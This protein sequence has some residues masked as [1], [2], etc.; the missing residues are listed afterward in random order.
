MAEQNQKNVLLIRGIPQEDFWEQNPHME[1][2]PAVVDLVKK[3]GYQIGGKLMWS[4]YLMMDPDSQ[5][6]SMD[7]N[8]R[9]RE[10][11]TNYFGN[12]DFDM[13]EPFLKETMVQYPHI[14]M[15]REKKRY[16]DAES[17]YDDMLYRINNSSDASV[18]AMDKI[19]FLKS[20]DS[21]A[22]NIDKMKKKWLDTTK[23]AGRSKGQQ[24][25]GL[26]SKKAMEKKANPV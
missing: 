19:S 23:N 24:Q 25:G 15:T 16:F 3:Y 14:A 26:F 18:R 5:F 11:M 1:Y 8:D 9:K 17:L 13:D 22:D 7:F 20:L 21:I 4:I 2:F 10:V 12:A 6:F